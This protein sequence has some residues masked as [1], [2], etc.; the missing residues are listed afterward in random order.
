MYDAYADR[1]TYVHTYII[2]TYIHMYICSCT[3]VHTYVRTQ[4]SVRDVYE[5]V[6]MYIHLYM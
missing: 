2:H 1:F 4:A 5:Q 3:Y 6:C